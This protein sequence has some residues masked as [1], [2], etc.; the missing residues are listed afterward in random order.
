MGFGLKGLRMAK[1]PMRS[2]PPR[3]GGRTVGDHFGL[4]MAAADAA[5]PAESVATSSAPPPGNPFSK[6]QSSH[7]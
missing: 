4:A 1:M 2:E 3:R 7:R 5:A 6:A